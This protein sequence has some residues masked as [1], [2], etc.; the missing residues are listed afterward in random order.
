MDEAKTKEGGQEQRINTLVRVTD[1][2]A[3]CS[4]RRGQYCILLDKLFVLTHADER[5]WGE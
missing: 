5:K 2:G 4:V 1:E 3:G